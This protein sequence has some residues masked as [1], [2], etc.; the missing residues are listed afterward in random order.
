MSIIG[1]TDIA[2]GVQSVVVDHDPE[3]DPTD[4]AE[5]TKIYSELTGKWYDK[6]D[7]GSTT[8]VG[9]TDNQELVEEIAQS[10]SGYDATGGTTVANSPAWTDIPLDTEIRKTTGFTHTG[11]SAEVTVAESDVYLVLA[12][13]NYDQTGGDRSDVRGRILVNGSPL[14]GTGEETAY[15]RNAAQGRGTLPIMYQGPLTANDVVKVQLQRRSG[16]ATISLVDGSKLVILKI[17]GPKGD[18]GDAGAGGSIDVEDGGSPEGSF[19]TLNFGTGLLVTDSGG[20][21]ATVDAAAA[22]VFGADF[23]S[24]E[25]L[26]QS[27]T[28]SSTFQDKLSLTTPT[29]LTGTYLV[30]F[31][32]RVW[33]G[34]VADRVQCQLYNSTDAT[35]LCG[36][37]DHEPED[38]DDRWLD[39]GFATVSFSGSAKTFVIQWRE[40]DGNTAYID[41]ARI[42]FW[43]V[44]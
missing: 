1:Y 26:T 44:A 17:R 27:G 16:A 36:P 24:E 11:S 38:N 37:A 18:K 41:Q 29:G 19:D 3:V 35:V 7:S 12:S 32:A 15:S 2:P 39:G 31:S 4:V 43:R 9:K 25:D 8:N 30:Q 22:S 13:V 6:R 14:A 28:T 5:G 10:F 34:G 40:Q 21:K 33:Q 42:V 23:Q 20:G